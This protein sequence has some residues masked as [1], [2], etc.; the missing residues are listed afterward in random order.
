M[1]EDKVVALTTLLKEWLDR[2]KA[3]KKEL[4]SL[5]GKVLKAANGVFTGRHRVLATERRAGIR[6]C[7]YALSEFISV[8]PPAHLHDLYT[9]GLELL[10]H[11]L[12]VRVR[13]PQLA[14][15]LRTARIHASDQITHDYRAQRLIF[16][17][18]SKEEG[19]HSFSRP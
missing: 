17:K 8:P 1:P 19:G 11:L 10:A 6:A 9:S 12:V 3:T 14:Q 18:F 16:D 2:T 15:R 5:P 4:A 13:D 7:N